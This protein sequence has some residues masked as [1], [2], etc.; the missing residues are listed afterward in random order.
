MRG[1]RGR[2]VR[3]VIIRMVC[4]SSVCFL[5]KLLFRLVWV[6]NLIFSIN[7]I[8]FFS[9]FL[10]IIHNFQ[11]PIWIPPSLSSPFPSDFRLDYIRQL[12]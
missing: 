1:E 11:N 8:P 6:T 10:A 4:G 12:M 2:V 5:Y 9:S 7:V 3:Y